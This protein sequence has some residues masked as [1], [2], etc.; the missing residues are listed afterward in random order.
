M[1]EIMSL[2][3][4]LRKQHQNQH[5]QRMLTTSP[6][7]RKFNVKLVAKLKLCCGG[8]VILTRMFPIELLP[9]KASQQLA[10]SVDLNVV[11]G[12]HGLSICFLFSFFA[13]LILVTTSSLLCSSLAG[14]SR[15]RGLRGRAS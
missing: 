4:K 13:L 5:E 6:A 8:V 14:E 1:V 11:Q 2:L 15:Q 7:Q 12:F 3:L 9:F 10:K